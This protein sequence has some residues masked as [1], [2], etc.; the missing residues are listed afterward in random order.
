[1]EL[2]SV[3]VPIYN[4]EPYLD[5]CISSIIG[6]T[7]RNYELILVDDGST[8][9]SLSI[10]NSWAGKDSRIKVIHKQNG[11]VS[12]ARNAGLDNASGDFVF[13][14][15]ADDAILVHCLEVLL[16]C[17]R[18]HNSDV[19]IGKM[20][21]SFS[22]RR[23][24]EFSVK[25]EQIQSSAICIKDYFDFQWEKRLTTGRLIKRDLIGSIRFD[26]S[27][28]VGEDTIFFYNILKN[29]PTKLSLFPVG[30]YIVYRDHV[31]ATTGD[32]VLSGFYNTGKWCLENWKDF[33]SEV[34]NYILQEGFKN[35]FLYRYRCRKSHDCRNKQD[36]FLLLHRFV[37]DLIRERRIPIT[38]RI[39]FAAAVY[40]PSVYSFY[41]WWKNRK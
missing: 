7:Y 9:A 20:E 29:H 26:P 31:S 3:I 11:G 23:L 30:I 17:Q 15:D 16:R 1:M 14:C 34:K 28:S 32:K 25:K 38:K 41:T 33:C 6:Q 22:D 5:R 27:I 37:P 2:I 19:S 21:A 40:V 39:P 12:S 10:C 35:L 18:E 36:V 4:A 13:F 8:D 24:S